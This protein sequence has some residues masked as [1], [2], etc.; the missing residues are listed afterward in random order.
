MKIT[1][2]TGKEKR[3]GVILI[4]SG[5]E[6]T[7]VDAEFLNMEHMKGSQCHIKTVSG[8]G[9]LYTCE[10]DISCQLGNNP[11]TVKLN[12]QIA[13]NFEIDMDNTELRKI[14]S[15]MEQNGLTTAL[16]STLQINWNRMLVCGVLGADNLKLLGDLKLREFDGMTVYQTSYGNV[17]FGSI[18]N[19]ESKI[20][21]PHATSSIREPKRV[22]IDTS[23]NETFVYDHYLQ[24]RQ[25]LKNSQ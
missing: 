17:P 1:V 13:R 9:T 24:S 25:S 11:T 22:S 10:Q 23:C 18:K 15:N 14:L 19:C 3:Q 7:F 4:D 16:D 2:T 20:I 8:Q 5:S 21:P 12:A 6:R